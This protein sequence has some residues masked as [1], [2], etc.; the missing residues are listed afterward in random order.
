M[1]KTDLV[2]EQNLI[3]MAKEDID[4]FKVLYKKYSQKLY[5]YCFYRLGK[6]K[7]MTED[8]VSETFV[9]A[10]EKFGTFEF[11][12]K[13]FIVWLYTIAH[14]LIIDLYRDKKEGNVSLDALPIPPKE[15]S[16]EIIEKLSMEELIDKIDKKS[17]D[18]PDIVRNIFT[19]RHTEDLTFAQIGNL[20][21]LS[22]GA[23]KMRYYRGIE[24][25]KN[26]VK[27]G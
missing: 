25:L 12:N 20:L 17:K 15:E 18:L 3:K 8:I 23:V 21:G 19:L 10:I 6:N 22:E 14:N 24:A 16:T 13:P 4:N 7:E 11:A 26:M 9:K 27:S 2:E 5:R 1:S